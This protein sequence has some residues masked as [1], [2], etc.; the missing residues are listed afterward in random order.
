ME[1][2]PAPRTTPG[3]SAR[4]RYPPP[5]RPTPPTGD[6]IWVTSRTLIAAVV[7]T[8]LIATGLTAAAVIAI[9]DRGPV[10]P[11]GAQGIPGPP[12]RAIRGAD[13]RPR[14]AALSTEAL[15]D[16]IDKD[17]DAVADALRDSLGTAP[18]DAGS[19]DAPS[20]ATLDDLQTTVDDLRDEFGTLCRALV[21]DALV[22]V[23]LPC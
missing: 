8:A 15:V 10:G 13:D 16:A 2:P 3:P 9:V 23:T 7:L 17:P 21:D 12:G 20:A 5:E 14:T 22:D 18:P 19:A 1:P 11:P 4:P 6:D